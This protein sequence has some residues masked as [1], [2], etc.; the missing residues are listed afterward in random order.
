MKNFRINHFC[1]TF[2]SH[3]WIK[4]HASGCIC[5]SQERMEELIKNVTSDTKIVIV[6]SDG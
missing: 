5:L 3:V 4:P 1:Y 2:S 6:G